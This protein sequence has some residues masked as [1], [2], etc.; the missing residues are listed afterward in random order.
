VQ[1]LLMEALVVLGDAPCTC[2]R[3]PDT[4]PGLNA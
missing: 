1:D 2:L 4:L 3:G